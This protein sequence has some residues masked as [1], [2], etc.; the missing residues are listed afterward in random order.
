MSKA[1]KIE[2]RL[3]VCNTEAGKDYA[4]VLDCLSWS[5][6]YKS[7][8]CRLSESNC[9]RLMSLLVDANVMVESIIAHGKSFDVKIAAGDGHSWCVEPW[10]DTS[11]V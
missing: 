4:I 5:F 9:L 11:K 3:H 7:F 2:I 10:V 8:I 6:Y 1:I